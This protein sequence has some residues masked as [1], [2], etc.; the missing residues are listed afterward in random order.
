M[1]MATCASCGIT[2]TMFVKSGGN[3]GLGISSKA[4]DIHKTMLPLLPKNGLTL[5]G[6]SAARELFR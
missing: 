3:L 6:Y 4:I 1:V 2:K 5:S